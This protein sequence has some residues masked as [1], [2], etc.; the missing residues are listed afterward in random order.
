MYAEH[1]A[2]QTCSHRSAKPP[3]EFRPYNAGPSI[4]HYRYRSLARGTFISNP[5]DY[6]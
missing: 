4:H 2:A 3:D 6:Q 1:G 5:N